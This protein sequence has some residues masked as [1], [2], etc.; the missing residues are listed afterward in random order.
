MILD[1][2]VEKDGLLYATSQWVVYRNPTIHRG[3]GLVVSKDKGKSW[4]YIATGSVL[5]MAI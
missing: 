4:S 2:I 3:H 1:K 5:L